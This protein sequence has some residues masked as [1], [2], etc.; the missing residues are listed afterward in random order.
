[1]R[2]KKEILEN[3]CEAAYKKSLL[4]GRALIRVSH[5]KQGSIIMV[6]LPPFFN[7]MIIE[8]YDKKNNK[9]N[10]K[11]FQKKENCKS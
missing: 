10:P 11:V 5:K 8:F 9:N 4:T 1:M 6:I 7:D 3:C 2:L